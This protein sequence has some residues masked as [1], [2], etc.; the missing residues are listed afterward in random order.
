M[1]FFSCNIGT[2]GPIKGFSGVGVPC[3]FLAEPPKAE[4]RSCRNSKVAAGPGAAGSGDS[5]PRRGR[6]G[7]AGSL[8]A[9]EEVK[10]N[11]W[12]ATLRPCQSG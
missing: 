1:V 7:Q 12:Q 11:R 5:M 4:R 10:L 2:L 9:E 3:L 6:C 8:D